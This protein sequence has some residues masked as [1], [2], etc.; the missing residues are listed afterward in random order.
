MQAPQFDI[1]LFP[2]RKVGLRCFARLNYLGQIE[3]QHDSIA[4]SRGTQHITRLYG[5]NNCHPYHGF[6]LLPGR[7]SEMLQ[8]QHLSNNSSLHSRSR[9]VL[10]STAAKNCCRSVYQRPPG[11]SNLACHNSNT[12]SSRSHVITSAAPRPRPSPSARNTVPRD[13]GFF[14]TSLE[15][16]KQELASLAAPGTSWPPEAAPFQLEAAEKSLG[17]KFLLVSCGEYAEDH[18]LVG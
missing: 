9:N 6:S 12:V 15:A 3:I 4:A 14:P 11:L 7:T 10:L 8:Q 16:A 5:L 2:C 1:E 13:F 18:P 17:G